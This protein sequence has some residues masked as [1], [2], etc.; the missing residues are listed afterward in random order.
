MTHRTKYILRDI[1]GI[2]FKGKNDT[3]FLDIEIINNALALTNQ[4][5]NTLKET[6][7]DLFEILGMRNLS[8]F[9]GEMFVSSLAESSKGK[10]KKN[11]HQDGYPDL[12]VMTD[13]GSKLWESL[14]GNNQD[15]MPFSNFETGGIEIKSTCGSLPT[16]EVFRKKGLRKPEIEDERIDH[17]RGYDWKAHHRETNNLMGLYWDFV[18]KKPTICGVF[19]CQDI[20]PDDWGK[21]VRPKKGGGRTT[22]VSI[23]ARH[24]IKKMYENWIAV[25]D[26]VRYVE[27]FDRFNKSN[28]IASFLNK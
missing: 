28:L 19:F 12:L 10:L 13:E 22:S 26:D 1:K 21:I 23:M 27:F 20:N 8:A 4:K 15:K 24:G 25:I 9:L 16:P 3:L 18:D 14:K 7:E 2:K 6:A 11:P 17:V 5:M